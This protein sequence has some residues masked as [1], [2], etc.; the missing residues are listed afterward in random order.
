MCGDGGAYEE[1]E[2]EK[3]SPGETSM[4]ADFW[5]A[6]GKVNRICMRGRQKALPLWGKVLADKHDPAIV[7]KD[8]CLDRHAAAGKEMGR[9][10]VCYRYGVK[11]G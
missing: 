7:P 2:A 3:I 5:R 10:P 9:A 8:P 4:D 1:D 6:R 11:S